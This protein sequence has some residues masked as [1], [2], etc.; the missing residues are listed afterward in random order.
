[1]KGW[2][3][4]FYYIL[5]FDNLHLSIFQYNILDIKGC[6]LSDMI[7]RLLLFQCQVAN[8]WQILVMLLGRWLDAIQGCINMYIWYTVF[9]LY[10]HCIY[11]LRT[12]CNN[13]IPYTDI[14]FIS[15]AYIHDIVYPHLSA[16]KMP[17][18]GWNSSTSF[19]TT[20]LLRPHIF[21]WSLSLYLHTRRCV[22]EAK[23]RWL[24]ASS[25]AVALESG[26][27]QSTGG[28]LLGSVGDFVDG[29]KLAK[30]LTYDLYWYIQI[31]IYI[32]T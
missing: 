12:Q 26:T 11:S 1:M 32:F 6:G 10:L 23:G 31:Y 25:S 14:S 5:C 29:R 16:R 21:I 27:P 3:I 22:F 8:V 24:Q 17:C 7:V 15:H 28:L 13:H 18:S 20:F 2:F 19:I 9:I 30:Q 4:F